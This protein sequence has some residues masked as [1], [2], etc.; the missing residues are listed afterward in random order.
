MDTP[1]YIFRASIRLRDGRRI[2]AQNFGLKAFKIR[3]GV[4][5]PALN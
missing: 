2:Y 4:G 5:L 1:D 3:S